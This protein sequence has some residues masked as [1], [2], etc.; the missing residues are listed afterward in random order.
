M[1]CPTGCTLQD[2]YPVTP[3][4]VEALM[5]SL[6][7]KQCSSDP[8]PTWLLKANAD[9]FSLFLCQLFNSCLEHG[10]VPSSFK[11]GYVTPLLKKADLDA[12]D[13][14]SY[15]PITI[16]LHPICFDEV[17][18]WMR[19]NRLQVNPSKTEVPWCASGQRQHQIPTSP[20]R[21]GSTYVLPVGPILCSRSRDT[22]RLRR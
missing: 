4:D 21:I 15:R 2:F 17:S 13:V 20:V 18:S 6:P 3:A 22:Y 1:F 9:I 5:R 11:S 14:K 19:T 12:A 7:N 16:P 10:T 8:Q